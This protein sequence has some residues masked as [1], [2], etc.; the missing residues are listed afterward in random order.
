MLSF[1]LFQLTGLLST[2]NALN[3]LSAI[4]ILSS[5]AVPIYLSMKVKKPIRTLT[6][7]LSA[8][9]LMHA[10]YHLAII[11]GFEFLGAGIFDPLSVLVLIIFG[12]TYLRLNTRKKENDEL[13]VA[14]KS[15]GS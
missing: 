10:A 3:L 4:A 2:Y 8:F 14:T 6:L 7:I 15:A 1:F 13:N 5:V 11:L 9:V 12:L